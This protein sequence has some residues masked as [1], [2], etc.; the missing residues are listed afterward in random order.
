ME[1]TFSTNEERSQALETNDDIHFSLREIR[2]LD[3][4][5]ETTKM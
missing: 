3:R 1:T 2:G 5:L 4:A